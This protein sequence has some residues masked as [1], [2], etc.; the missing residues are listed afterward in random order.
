M[1]IIDFVSTI[2]IVFRSPKSKDNKC[3][4][5][6]NLFNVHMFFILLF[7][8][9]IWDDPKN[10]VPNLDGNILFIKGGINKSFKMLSL[11]WP[12]IIYSKPAISWLT[13]ISKL[14]MPSSSDFLSFFMSISRNL[15]VITTKVKLQDFFFKNK[16][17]KLSP[18]DPQTFFFFK[19]LVF[20]STVWSKSTKKLEITFINMKKYGYLVTSFF[21]IH[22]KI[23]YRFPEISKHI[24]FSLHT[25]LIS[26]YY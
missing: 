26:C 9:I 22:I 7:Y 6:F 16:I 3:F 21:F 25:N 23:N 10:L 13:N 11:L 18:N 5:F 24:P 8:V 19:Y 20:Y 4:F 15:I 14:K 12:F 17:D 2:P 1:S